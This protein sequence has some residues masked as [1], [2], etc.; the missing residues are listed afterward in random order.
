MKQSWCS[1][2]LCWR[3][4]K[5]PWQMTKFKNKKN[6]LMKQ[7]C[8][9]ALLETTQATLSPDRLCPT[10]TFLAN[11][12]NS[13]FS[14]F[15]AHT[16]I[17]NLQ[18]YL[19]NDFMLTLHILICCKWYGHLSQLIHGEFKNLLA[20]H[21]HHVNFE[22]M[23]DLFCVV[24]CCFGH[25]QTIFLQYLYLYFRKVVFSDGFLDFPLHWYVGLS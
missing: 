14:K 4:S 1:A 13:H 10:H 6:W 12:K 2:P 11:C 9:S 18:K 24:F 8:C 7:S 16:F 23:S 17:G 19:N 5:Q 22:Y 3:H 21:N 15:P 20:H 25:L